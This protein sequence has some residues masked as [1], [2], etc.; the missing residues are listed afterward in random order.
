M[1]SFVIVI[2]LLSLVQLNPSSVT[3]FIIVIDAPYKAFPL[4]KTGG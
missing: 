2:M 3:L 1:L 4:F